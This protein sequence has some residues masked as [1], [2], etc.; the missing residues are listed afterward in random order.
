MQ[1][2][3]L[4]NAVLIARTAVQKLIIGTVALVAQQSTYIPVTKIG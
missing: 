3:I 1:F 2:A 4:T